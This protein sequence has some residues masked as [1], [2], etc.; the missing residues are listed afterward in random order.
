MLDFVTVVGFAA[1]PTLLGLQGLPATLAY[2][3]AFVHLTLTLLTRFP[4]AQRGMVPLRAHGLIELLVGI[5]L[6]VLPFVLGWTGVART[7]YVA[8]GV[9]I[10]AVWAL[11]EYNEHVATA[12]NRQDR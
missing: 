11:S 9:V 10:L 6:V 5:A 4:P 8:A 2:G 12:S 3:L 7:F 1:A